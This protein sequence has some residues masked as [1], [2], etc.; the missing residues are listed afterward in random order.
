MWQPK[1]NN[2]DIFIGKKTKI[3]D[4][5]DGK[6]VAQGTLTYIRECLNKKGSY[7]VAVLSENGYTNQVCT[8]NLIRKVDVKL[9]EI[10]EEVI[11]GLP[12]DC[13]NIITEYV[14]DYVEI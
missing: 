2:N 10:G 1:N 8:S 12:E 13:C 7:S 5:K 11:K 14:Y 6:L 4:K 9:F 3:Y